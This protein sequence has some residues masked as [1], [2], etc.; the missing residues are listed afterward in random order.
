M[1][2]RQN[3]QASCLWGWHKFCLEAQVCKICL[4]KSLWKCRLRKAMQIATTRY[5]AT[6]QALHSNLNCNLFLQ[7]HLIKT[8]ST[9]IFAW[10]AHSSRPYNFPN[11]PYRFYHFYFPLLAWNLEPVHGRQS[12]LPLI[13][14]PSPWF[15]WDRVLLCTQTGLALQILLPLSSHGFYNRFLN[16]TYNFY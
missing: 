4:M 2:R 12:T 15:S 11:C 5:R 9:L 14:Q 16:Y 1:E 8:K 3:R 13:Y 6:T 7:V 10:W